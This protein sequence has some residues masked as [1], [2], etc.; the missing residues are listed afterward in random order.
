MVAAAPVL[1]AATH[2]MNVKAEIDRLSSELVKPDRPW[3][4]VAR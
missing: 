3:V 2:N 4:L 1:L